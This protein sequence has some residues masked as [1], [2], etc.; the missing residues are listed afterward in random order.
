[1]QSEHNHSSCCCSDKE[2]SSD[3][4]SS[5]SSGLEQTGTLDAFV[6]D[7]QNDLLILAMFELR[8]WDQGELQLFQLQEKLNA[9]LSF[10]LDGEMEETFPHL[11]GKPVRIELR[12]LHEPS[13]QALGFLERAQQQLSHQQIELQVV[14]IEEQLDACGHDGGRCC[15]DVATSSKNES[16]CCQDEKSSESCCHS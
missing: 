4:C 8:P 15:N 13:E 3:H 9:Y 11:K 10:V 14:H 16:T 1:M 6:H 7:K 12:S 2:G 5:S